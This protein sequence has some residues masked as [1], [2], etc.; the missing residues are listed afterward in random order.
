M[1]KQMSAF[2]LPARAAILDAFT[3][4]RKATVSYVISVRLSA[5]NSS[6]LTGRIL[7]KLDI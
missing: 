7:M 6:A 3:K 1:E 4:L 5:W 2:G